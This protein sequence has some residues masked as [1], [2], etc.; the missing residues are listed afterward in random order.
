[1]ENF[2]FSDPTK[3]YLSLLMVLGRL[4]LFAVMV[5]FIPSVW[6]RFS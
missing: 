2:H 6:R 3:I 1:M 4:E 5:L